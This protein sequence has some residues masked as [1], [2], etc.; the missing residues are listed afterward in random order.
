MSHNKIQLISLITKYSI[1]H[2]KDNINELVETY[3][4]P[5]PIELRNGKV[6]PRQEMSINREEADVIIVNQLVALVKK[7]SSSMCVVCDDTDVFVLLLY[8]YCRE[9]LICNVTMESPIVGRCVIDLKATP[10]KHQNIADSLPG[11]HAL[12]GCDTV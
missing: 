8:F 9:Q 10:N 1:D 7:G 11:V 6:T 3:D 12:S 5:I 2:L 4:D